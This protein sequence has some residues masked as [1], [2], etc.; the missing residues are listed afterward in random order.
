MVFADNVIDKGFNGSNRGWA[1]GIIVGG[2]VTGVVIRDNKIAN[3]NSTA[4][5]DYSNPYGLGAI[6]I[7]AID[8]ASS[9]IQIVNN[10]IVNTRWGMKIGGATRN[11]TVTGNRISDIELYVFKTPIPESGFASAGIKLG[12]N[13]I[14]QYGTLLDNSGY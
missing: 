7:E 3:I 10:T 2:G 1:R 9:N 13:D 11:L 5:V 4:E 14:T 8:S 12:G 6:A